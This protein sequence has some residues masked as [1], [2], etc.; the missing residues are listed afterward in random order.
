MAMVLKVSKFILSKFYKPDVKEVA[1]ELAKEGL[2]EKNIKK[3][4]KLSGLPLLE[5]ILKKFGYETDKI[6]RK[7]YSYTLVLAKSK[8]TKSILEIH[9]DF[10]RITYEIQKILGNRNYI[11]N[12]VASSSNPQDGDDL[13]YSFI[14]W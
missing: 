3:L 14:K 11:I 7:D 9:E 1:R 12:M 8:K 6:L 4:V 5:K 10:T 13:L 2:N